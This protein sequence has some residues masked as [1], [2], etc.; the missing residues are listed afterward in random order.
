MKQGLL[1][2]IFHLSHDGQLILQVGYLQV[3]TKIA[4]IFFL[5]FLQIKGGLISVT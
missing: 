4:S 3:F 1:V 5:N 2:N